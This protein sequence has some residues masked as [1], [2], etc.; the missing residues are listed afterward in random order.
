MRQ[1]NYDTKSSAVL[2]YA[3][4]LAERRGIEGFALAGLSHLQDSA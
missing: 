2:R 3:A 4:A 1:R